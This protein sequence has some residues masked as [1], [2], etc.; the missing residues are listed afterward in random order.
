MTSQAE[1]QN[2][3]LLY[4]LYLFYRKLNGSILE[5]IELRI[6][7]SRQHP[8]YQNSHSSVISYPILDSNIPNKSL[9]FSTYGDRE[10]IPVTF[11]L[12]REE[13]KFHFFHFHFFNMNISLDTQDWNSRL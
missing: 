12:K 3:K 1:I 6:D 5:S 7:N 9:D 13:I 4:V 8:I 2:P 11:I 10:H